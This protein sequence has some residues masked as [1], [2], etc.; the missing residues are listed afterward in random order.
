MIR[1]VEQFMHSIVTIGKRL[2]VWLALIAIYSVAVGFAVKFWDIHLLEWGGT[3]GLLDSIIL[4]LL[5]SFRNR[6]AYDRW[7]EGRQLWGQLTNDIRNLAWKLAAFVPTDLLARSSAGAI[8]RAYPEALKLH[9]RGESPRIQDFS[10][11][12][13]T[14]DNPAHVPSFLSGRLIATVAEWK[15]AGHLDGDM[16]RVLDPH[17]RA[18]LDV[19]GGCER[20]RNTPL[21]RSYKV[22]LR[23]G[24]AFNVLLA[25]WYTLAEIGLWGVPLLLLACFFLLGVELIDTV[26]EEPFG[27]ER[28]D[29][30]LDKYCRTIQESVNVAF[31][32]TPI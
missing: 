28:D 30:D 27:Q 19:C 31:P 32:A 24:I 16:F 7:W 12:E 8:L 4:G 9:L 14:A 15:R 22:L 23:T 1:G 2:W 17:L 6:T 13:Q 11:F 5:L 20:I 25:P 3:A 21:S 18:L 26:V 10:G 29:L